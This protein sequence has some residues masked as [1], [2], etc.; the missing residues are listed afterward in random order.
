L[1]PSPEV[2]PFFGRNYKWMALSNTTLGMPPAS[3]NSTS[4]IIALPVIFRGIGEEGHAHTS[5]R[6]PR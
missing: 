3:L 4:L 6:P 1:P 2:E 5:S